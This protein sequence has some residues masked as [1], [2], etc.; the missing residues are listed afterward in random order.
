MREERR[1][2][3]GAWAR[4]ARVGRG[5]SSEEGTFLIPL[6]MRG[7]DVKPTFWKQHN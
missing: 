3:E 6:P 2:R 1:V 5:L 7:L 4:R